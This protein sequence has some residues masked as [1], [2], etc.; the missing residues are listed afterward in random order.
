MPGT[1]KDPQDQ[2]QWLVDRAD[3]TDHVVRYA[4]CIDTQDWQGWAELFTDDGIL[5]VPFDNVTKDRLASFLA[6]N[7]QHYPATQHMMSNFEISI[8]GDVARSRH[9]LHSSHIPDEDEPMRH[10]DV[11][12]WYDADYR[13]TVDGWRFTRVS[14]TFLWQDGELFVPGAEG[15]PLRAGRGPQSS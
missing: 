4:R 13:R 12:G 15:E 9:Y 10:S 14:L 5:E 6:K 2:L 8:D 1:P 7:L 3:I 11:G